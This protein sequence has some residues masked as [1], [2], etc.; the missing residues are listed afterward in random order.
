MCNRIVQIGEVISPQGEVLVLLKGPGG[1]YALPFNAVF[2]GPARKESRAYWKGKMGAVDVIVPNVERFGEK[3]KITGEQRWEDVPEGTAL[4]GLLLPMEIAKKTGK[5][6][7]LLKV[8]TQQASPDQEA[9][10]G[11]D[12]APVFGVTPPQFLKKIGKAGGANQGDAGGFA[13]EAL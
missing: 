5:P 10:L 13:L 4:Q 9:R 12:R 2:G 1:D 7:R 6:Y 11:N 8:L 3:S